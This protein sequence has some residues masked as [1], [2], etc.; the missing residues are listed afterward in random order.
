MRAIRDEGLGGVVLFGRNIAS[1]AQLADL[2]GALHAAAAP[3]PLIIC[4]DEEG[5]QIAR[6]DPRLGFDVI[7][8]AAAVGAQGSAENAR[9]VGRQ[10]GSLL[11]ASAINLN[12]APVVDLNVNPTNPSIGALE[13]SYSAD[14]MVVSALAAAAIEGQHEAGVL[15]TLKHFPGLGSAT[16][17]TDEEFV[18]VTATWSATELAPYRSL[19]RHGQADVIMAANALNGQL[20]RR[21][22]AS[23]S[24]ATHA[25]LRSQLGWDGPVMTD[26][27]QAAALRDAYS[28][29]DILRLALAAGNDLLLLA[30]PPSDDP[31]LIG[32]TL[33]TLVGLV[34]GG[35][36]REE[37][38]VDAGR[39]V[40]ALTARL[41]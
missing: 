4:I 20:D 5:G 21:Y 41:T 40:A 9:Q 22:P 18:D 17:N 12:L 36:L 28:D 31:T 13:R 26:D 8:S 2:C 39:R 32:D 25:S 33:D 27:L 11:R 37:V 3:R 7:P 35:T 10:I 23:L 19:I 24:A 15:T 16:G 34:M 38:V 1:P 6:L 29:A 30:K 14:P